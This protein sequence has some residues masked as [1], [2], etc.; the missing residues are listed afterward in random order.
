MRPSNHRRSAIPL[1]TRLRLLALGVVGLTAASGCAAPP[2]RVSRIAFGSCVRQ[3]QPQP[4]WDA[5]VAAEPDLFIFLGDNI[6]GDTEEMDEL[7]AAY[8]ALAEQ[9]GI[10]KL[11]ATCPLL[12]TWDD[13]DYGVNDGGADYPK[14]RRSQEVFVDFWGDPP[15]SPRRRR[16]GV[17]DAYTFGERGQRVQVI[18]LDTRYF[19]SPLPRGE[20]TDDADGRPGW[21]D[22]VTD[23][24]ATLLGRQQWEWLRQQLAQPAEVRLICSSIQVVSNEHRWEKWGNFPHERE[25]LFALIDSLEASGVIF[26]SGDRHSAELSAVDPGVGYPL[27]DITASA[28]NQS[29]GWRNEINPHRIGSQYFEPNFGVITIDWDGTPPQLTLEI[30]DE[31]GEPTIRHAVT[32][33]DLQPGATA[34]EPAGG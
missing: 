29:V 17:Y 4:I 6:Y 16:P 7:R 8:R 23:T 15:D 9:P 27:Y 21:Y 31:S 28:L 11:R 34:L 24:D 25:R 30:R 26:L 13:H 10:Q 20:R 14:K 12:A 2:D 32:L 1:E 19:R 3:N 33:Q 22:P 5:V 18:L